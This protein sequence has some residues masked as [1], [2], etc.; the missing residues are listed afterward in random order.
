MTHIHLATVEVLSTIGMVVKDEEGIELLE[1]AGAD[2]EG[3]LVKIPE[4]LLRNAL[5]SAPSRVPI[6]NRK[7]SCS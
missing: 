3:E 2:I 5:S 6:Y 1:K 4:H 7:G